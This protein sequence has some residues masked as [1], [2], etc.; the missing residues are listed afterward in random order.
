MFSSKLPRHKPPVLESRKYTHNT[1]IQNTHK[2]Q[3]LID[4][5]LV[6]SHISRRLVAMS[7]HDRSS[8]FRSWILRELILEANIFLQ[9][10]NSNRIRT[11]LIKIQYNVIVGISRS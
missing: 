6:C 11:H 5:L 9:F 8:L 7:M 3:V 10:A 1:R 2:I 4:E